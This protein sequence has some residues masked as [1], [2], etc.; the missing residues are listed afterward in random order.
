MQDHVIV[1]V[2]AKHLVAALPLS[3]KLVIRVNLNGHRAKIKSSNTN[4]KR[5]GAWG[6]VKFVDQL[7]AACI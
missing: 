1:L 7:Y 3:L 5:A 6:F 2:V 4:L